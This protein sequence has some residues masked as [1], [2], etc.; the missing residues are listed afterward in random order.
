[1]EMVDG[2]LVEYLF[3]TSDMIFGNVLEFRLLAQVFRDVTPGSLSAAKLSRVVVAK[4]G[5][6]GAC[7]YLGV[8]TPR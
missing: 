7:L 6:R 4:A 3:E 5:A 2:D 8:K 1:M